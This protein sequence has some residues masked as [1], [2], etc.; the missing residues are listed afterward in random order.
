VNST[1]IYGKNFRKCHSVPPVQQ[2][3]NKKEE[4]GQNSITH[5][6]SS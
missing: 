3:K 2:L 5:I 4:I 6:I 1:L